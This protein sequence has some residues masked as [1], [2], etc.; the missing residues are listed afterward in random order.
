MSCWRST[1]FPRLARPRPPTWTLL[2]S[3][4]Q[5]A[6]VDLK[7]VSH[8][9]RATFHLFSPADRTRNAR[10]ISHSRLDIGVDP[11]AAGR[12]VQQEDPQLPHAAE[13]VALGFFKEKV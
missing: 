3:P 10:F 11:L 9:F 12:E 1:T 2:W 6:T 4:G 7:G 13:V 8:G 5:S